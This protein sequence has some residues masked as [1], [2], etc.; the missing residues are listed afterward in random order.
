MTVTVTVYV[1]N[2]VY[3]RNV[4]E[5]NFKRDT[6]RYSIKQESLEEVRRKTRAASL[7]Q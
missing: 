4:P 1:V 7:S 6:P 5:I 2:E 3:R